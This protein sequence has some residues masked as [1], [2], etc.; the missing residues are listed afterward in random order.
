[1]GPRTQAGDPTS[2][3][4]R[5]TS[6]P[7]VNRL[8]D[9]E[10]QEESSLQE[11]P[12]LSGS[13]M[14]RG[15]RADIY[16]LEQS[17][18]R[19]QS[20]TPEGSIQEGP[21]VMEDSV[22]F[23][24]V[25]EESYVADIGNDS[26]IGVEAE[27]SVAVEE[28]EVI[29][30]VP[31]Q[32]AKRGR[33][34][35][36]E[37]MEQPTEQEEEASKSRKRG[38][39]AQA[40]APETQKKSKKALAAPAVQPRR[41]KRVSEITEDE[42]S[43][44][45]VDTSAGASEQTETPPVA[46]RPRGRPRKINPQIEQ[47]VSIKERQKKKQKEDGQVEESETVEPVFKKPKVAEKSKKKPE[48][49]PTEKEPKVDVLES[50]K[51]VD[52]HGRPISKADLDQMSTTSVGSRFGRGRHLSVFRELD[53]ESIA[54]VGRTGRH[55]VKPIDF[56]RNESVHYDEEGG[57]QAIVKNAHEE[58]VPRKQSS[59]R[60]KGKKKRG[61]AA[62]EEEEEVELEPWEVEEGVFEG[63]YRDFD[64][65]TEL[66]SDELRKTGMVTFSMSIRI[67]LTLTDVA[68]AQKGI[69]PAD[70]ADGSFRYCKLGS[71]GDDSFLS[72]GFVELGPDQMKRT[73]NAR[74]MH[75]CFHVQSGAVE[76]KI[77]ENQ[78]V[79]R[80]GG[81]W[82]VPRGKCIFSLFVLSFTT[83]F[84]FALTFH[85]VLLLCTTAVTLC[86]SLVRRFVELFII[87]HTNLALHSSSRFASQS[88]SGASEKLCHSCR[89]VAGAGLLAC[90]VTRHP[91][92]RRFA[93][94]RAAI[95]PCCSYYSLFAASLFRSTSC[96]FN[97]I[98]LARG[99]FL[100][101]TAQKFSQSPKQHCLL[102]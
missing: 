72:W 84:P 23:N 56:W 8:L 46:G 51:L 22:V 31:K 66:S 52:V 60:Y 83:Q 44:P 2:S 14:R 59:Y 6:H 93:V 37:V 50:G 33:K 16:E 74:R 18:S 3:P 36:S 39:V 102:S 79:V 78:F 24:G 12:A 21:V 85:F 32:A 77:H 95:T 82:Q 27:I 64:P 88:G 90:C 80:R 81:V 34:R 4:I 9:F 75:M 26:T 43:S 11:T 73:K 48:V 40:Q 91:V 10:E 65:A 63:V 13:G 41:S 100:H 53:P 99:S 47:P 5:A 42:T 92:G 94:V 20:E 68:W 97:I 28:S 70:V 55:R 101:A 45:M 61:L 87:L 19:V 58:P 76:V 71:A 57:M 35:K 67:K 1:M 98:F 25:T 62:L 86:L 7:A 69:K 54:R 96:D 30:E 89:N 17:P 15:K 49:R 38:A 29:P